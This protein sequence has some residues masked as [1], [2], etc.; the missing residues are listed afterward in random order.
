MTEQNSDVAL[1]FDQ[2][3]R[4][5]T[6][7]FIVEMVE[8]GPP[9]MGL[10]ITLFTGGAIVSGRVIS[11]R[12][13]FEADPIGKTV[14]QTGQEAAQEQSPKEATAAQPVE[15]AIQINI[16]TSDIFARRFIHMT[17]LHVL[18]SKWQLGMPGKVARFR[19]D[20]IT[21]FSW[22]KSELAEREPR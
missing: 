14:W 3:D 19:L 9:N 15:G 22:G 21:G 16:T 7:Q 4:D 17:D 1:P 6:L 13:F 2:G 8:K 11:K 12:A 20:E 10:F 18:V 5:T